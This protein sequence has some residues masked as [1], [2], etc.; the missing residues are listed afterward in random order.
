[1]IPTHL[2]T[3]EL[4][5]LL[6][7]IFISSATLGAL[8]LGKEALV[9]FICL[10]CI[11]ANL[12]VLKQT[13]LFGLNATCADAFTIGATLGLNLLQEYFGPAIARKTIK[14]N[15]FLL[16][17][18]TI[19]SQ[20][21]LIYLPSNADTSQAAFTLI[22]GFMPRI[23]LASVTCYLISQSVDYLVYGFLKK[24][25]I[26]RFLL[27]RNYGSMLISQ[28]IDTILFSF[29]GLHGIVDSMGEIIIISYAIKVIA[30]A[31]AAPF[32]TLSRLFVKKIT[33]KT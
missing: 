14:I 33:S 17:F 27:I 32:A 13:T 6:Q 24:K 15:F 16:I 22:L 4:I 29:L 21:H 7:T 23:A 19:I 1:M 8:Y 11:L 25:L 5:F 26:N 20:I 12:F 3:N 30:I 28:L 9:S 31:L 18:Y 2:L 10:V